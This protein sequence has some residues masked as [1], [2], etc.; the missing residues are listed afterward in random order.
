MKV[1]QF[2]SSED[3]KK[4]ELECMPLSRMGKELTTLLLE[5]D[6]DVVAIETI[7][8]EWRR[9]Y[10]EAV[11]RDGFPITV[12]GTKAGSQSV[13]I[14]ARTYL[15]RMKKNALIARADSKEN[16]QKTF[17]KLRSKIPKIVSIE[18]DQVKDEYNEL[19]AFVS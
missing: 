3:I 2:D 7:Y 16:I 15:V 8:E 9:R 10:P 1:F 6:A 12:K 5:I 13:S 17:E 19:S 18:F 4:V 11:N 14:I